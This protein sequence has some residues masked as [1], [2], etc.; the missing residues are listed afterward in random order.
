MKERLHIYTRVSTSTQVDGTSLEVQKDNGIELSKKLGMDYK[1]HNEG[2]KSGSGD[3]LDGRP[4]LSNLMTMVRGGEVK[5]IFVYEFSRLSRNTVI[6][7]IIT[8]DFRKYGVKIHLMNGDYDLSSP[9][10]EMVSTILNS[11][12]RYER[13]TIIIRSKLGLRKSYEKGKITGQIPPL[14][15]KKDE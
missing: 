1:I 8:E 2:S 13:Q 10:D 4:I 11:V 12:S 15:Y 9:I 5:H 6:S 7:S 3:D 14:G